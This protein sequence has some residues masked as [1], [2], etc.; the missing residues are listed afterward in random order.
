[1]SRPSSQIT[2]SRALVAV[3]VPA[4]RRRDDEIAR[5][6]RAL[7]AVH[8]RVGARA[9]DD[10][11]ERGRRVVMAG[12]RLAGQDD[13]QARVQRG[14]RSRKCRARPGLQSTSTRRSACSIGTRRAA[15]SSGAR[16]SLQRQRCGTTR[17]CRSWRQQ[18]VQRGPQR[19]QRQRLERVGVRGGELRVAG[20]ERAGSRAHDAVAKRGS[21]CRARSSIER[22]TCLWGR[23]PKLPMARRCVNPAAS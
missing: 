12:R 13:L 18:R 16:S 10:Q 3:V 14:G 20:R 17:V 6:H 9:L 5:L 7:H 15:S 4:H 1:M 8:R 19:R 22:S 21:T 2:G 11:P 23:P